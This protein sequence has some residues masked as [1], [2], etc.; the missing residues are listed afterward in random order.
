MSK[1]EVEY[2]EAKSNDLRTD[3]EIMRLEQE[4]SK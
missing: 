4:T 1:I 3:A 2:A